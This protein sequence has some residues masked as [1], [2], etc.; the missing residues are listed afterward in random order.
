MPR[1][2]DV[3]P[4]ATPTLRRRIS[5]KTIRSTRSKCWTWSGTFRKHRTGTR[6]C[7]HIGGRGSGNKTVARILLALRDRV[8]LAERA[9]LEAGHLCGNHWCVNPRHLVWQT[10]S[11]NERMKAYHRS[12]QRD[13]DAYRSFAAEVEALAS[14][15]EEP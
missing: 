4:G 13:R 8:C 12:E 6:P 9:E 11:E 15:P 7:I 1:D 5:A 10:R 14:A 2:I 3:I